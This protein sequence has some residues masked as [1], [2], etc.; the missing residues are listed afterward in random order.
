[1]KTTINLQLGLVDQDDID[2]LV[3]CTTL[4]DTDFRRR[5]SY[6]E[7]W[8]DKESIISEVEISHL[9]ELANN[10]DVSVE[11]DKEVYLVKGGW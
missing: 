5:K 10:F 11:A 4:E 3:K 7:F 1:M 2:L 8:C 9:C 6:D